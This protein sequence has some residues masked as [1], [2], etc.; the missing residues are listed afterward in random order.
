MPAERTTSRTPL[1]GSRRR[2]RH[3]WWLLTD[4][5]WTARVNR[6]WWLLPVA[7]VAV[8]GLFAT[9][10]THVAVPYAVYTLF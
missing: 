8:I 9:A 2:A 6:L 3:L 5:L 4:V 10:T 1:A 7:A